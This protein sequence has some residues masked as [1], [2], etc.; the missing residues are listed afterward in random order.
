M[1][2]ELSLLSI[3]SQNSQIDSLIRKFE[4]RT[5]SRVKMNYINWD[6]AWSEMM[7]NSNTRS[8]VP[9]AISEVGTTWVPDLARVGAVKPLPSV[10]MEHLGG[11]KD[12]VPDLWKSCFSFG[13]PQ[14]WSMP[15]ISGS[16][17]IYYRRDLLENADIDPET[18]FANPQSMLEAVIRL[19]DMGIAFPWITSNV[20]SVNSLHLIST[21]IWAGGGDFTS[22]DGQQLLFAEPGAIENMAAFFQMGRYM[23]TKPEEYSYENAIDE[24]WRGDAAITMDGTWRYDMEKATANPDVLENL[25]VALAPGPAFVGGSNLV[26]WGN[27]TEKDAAWDFLTFLSEPEFVITMFN[28]TGLAPARLSLLNSPE[29]SNRA[30]GPI[31]ARALETGRSLPNHRFSGMVEDMLQY[32]FGQVWADMLRYPKKDP[33]DILIEHLVPL[34]DPWI[35]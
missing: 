24:F 11:E 31:F 20:T 14:M 7:S 15:W 22:E 34:K 35:A 8:D 30:F 25:G 6:S 2:I 12:Y 19:H 29:V 5:S 32:A 21:W 18:A 9:T 23:G 26:V 33:R 10:L 27:T 1:D 28:L 13:K 3:E 17:V 4:Q 16:R